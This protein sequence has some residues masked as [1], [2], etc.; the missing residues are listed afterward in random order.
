[1]IENGQNFCSCL[2]WSYLLRA[3]NSDTTIET[4]SILKYLFTYCHLS[5]NFFV[6]ENRK[7]KK[8]F[9]TLSFK[10]EWDILLLS[11]FLKCLILIIPIFICSRNAQAIFL[12]APQHN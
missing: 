2:N 9:L 10:G 12:D 6:P 7:I 3:D 4:G 11:Y 1:M 5:N 8:F